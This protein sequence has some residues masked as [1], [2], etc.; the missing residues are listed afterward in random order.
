MSPE[1]FNLVKQR[2]TP[3]AFETTSHI[4]P[5]FINLLFM[6]CFSLAF[7]ARMWSIALSSG[8]LLCG[9]PSFPLSRP[10]FVQATQGVGS[11]ELFGTVAFAVPMFE[12]E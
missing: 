9:Y 4:W 3:V 8:L 5:I 11:V 10:R 1:E 2:C 6:L 12:M 7:W